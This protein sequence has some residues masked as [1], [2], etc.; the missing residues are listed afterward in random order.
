[1]VNLLLYKG[2]GLVPIFGG[3]MGSPSTQHTEQRGW[4]KGKKC[5]P[6]RMNQGQGCPE[7]MWGPGKYFCLYQQV[8]YKNGTKFTGTCEL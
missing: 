6:G 2:R 1:M 5:A 8:D 7:T 4:I 3:L